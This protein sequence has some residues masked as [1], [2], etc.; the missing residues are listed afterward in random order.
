MVVLESQFR[1]ELDD[2]ESKKKK[3]KKRGYTSIKV[4]IT[5]SREFRARIKESKS[6]APYEVTIGGRQ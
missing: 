5:K 3:R 6:M 2:D 1:P 4:S